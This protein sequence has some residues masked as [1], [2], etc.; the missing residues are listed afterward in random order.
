MTSKSEQESRSSPS[1]MMVRAV[2]AGRGIST[3][4]TI[5]VLWVLAVSLLILLYRTPS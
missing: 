5:T 1:F 2:P 4:V 3:A